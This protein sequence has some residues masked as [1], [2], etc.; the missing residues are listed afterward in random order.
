MIISHVTYGFGMG[1][2]ETMLVN[3][4]N[5]Q[6][7]EG[8]E[9][10]IV[11]L[12]DIVEP[13]LV[14][15]LEPSV[16]IHLLGRPQGSHNPLYVVRLNKCLLRIHPDV[17]HLH[18]PSLSRYILLPSLRQRFCVTQHAMCDSNNTSGIKHAGAVFAISD[19]VRLDL[20]EKFGI[21]STT[22]YNGIEPK[23]IPFK[24]HTFIIGENRP[25]KILQLG[26]FDVATKGQDIL[27]NAVA[28]LRGAG[29]DVDVTFIGSGESLGEL[30]TLSKELGISDNTEFLGNRP[31]N[32]V[33]A[34]L[35]DYDL[36][37]QPSRC[38]GFGLTVV[39]AMAAG[40]PV[41]V[42]DNDGPMEVIAGG[43]YGYHFK[44]GSSR[45][46][47]DKISAII[48][49]YPD[50]EFIAAARRHVCQNFDVAKTA[51]HYIEKY[52]S[53]KTSAAKK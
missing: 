35:A 28:A 10:H 19:V 40:I 51:R 15:S 42:S 43:R 36:L 17:V 34:H 22:V 12:N 32:Y 45:D 9:V 24:I 13:T 39:E 26:R 7:L 50:K 4:A 29:R 25:F 49:N 44:S 37:V 5:Y 8:N 18:I 53:F 30:Q 11:V 14:S 31:Q 2:I 48:D 21:S 23:K 1:G 20:K 47:A 16:R 38:E 27:M 46:C 33:F 41:L 6:S 3:I 52:P